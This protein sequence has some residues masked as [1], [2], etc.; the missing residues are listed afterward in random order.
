MPSSKTPLLADSRRS[1]DSARSDRLADEEDVALYR[2][3]HSQPRSANHDAAPS[4]LP[5]RVRETLLLVWALLATAAVILLAV[6]MQHHQ[7]TSSG[8]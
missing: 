5:A 3:I 4:W 1:A 2:S 6:W 8:S 7:Q